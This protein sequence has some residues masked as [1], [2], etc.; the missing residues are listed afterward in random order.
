MQKYDSCVE[1]FNQL[2]QKID[3]FLTC[4]SYEDRCLTP[5][6][7]LESERVK[8]FLLFHVKEY[9]EYTYINKRYFKNKF[10]NLIECELSASNPIKCADNLMK[11]F[12]ENFI[13]DSNIVIDIS[14]FTRESLMIIIKFLSINK[15]KFRKI[16][17]FYRA[18][19][20]SGELS[21]MITQIRSVLGYMGQINDSNPI[22]LILLSGFEYHRAK[23]M[24]ETIQPDFL[25]IGYGELKYSIS[26][27]LHQK[28]I[29]FTNE[30]ILSCSAQANLNKFT[31]SL[32]SI[33][34]IKEQIRKIIEN[35]PDHSF[36][37][38]PLSNKISTVGAAM[39]AIENPKLQI[40][41]SE[42][43]NYN[44]TGYSHTLN[45]CFVE[46]INF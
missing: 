23:E 16:Y 40:C 22:H 32:I 33:T 46:E 2:P 8:N 26:D 39:A 21:S 12:S 43:T 10:Q 28:N 24:I 41:Y 30:L 44:V 7:F 42:V 3:Y 25:S 11:I 29:E 14:T 38:A 15:E 9:N 27:T 4:V 6:N 17:L 34:S 31:H 5:V 37:I 36:V 45:T 20:V 18:A 35:Y 1:A 13:K 19:E